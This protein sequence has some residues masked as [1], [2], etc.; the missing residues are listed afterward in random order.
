M[1]EALYLLFGVLQAAGHGKTVVAAA[2]R[3]RV[4]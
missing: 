4:A 3:R 1:L 2:R